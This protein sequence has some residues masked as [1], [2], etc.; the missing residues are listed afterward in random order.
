LKCKKSL[1]S[2][3]L[4]L[5]LPASLN[6]CMGSRTA[7]VSSCTLLTAADAQAALGGPVEAPF[8]GDGGNT[9]PKSAASLCDY[10]LKLKTDKTKV[11]MIRLF[12]RWFDREEDAAQT[13]VGWTSVETQSSSAPVRPVS[14]L[15][16]QAIWVPGTQQLGVLKGRIM[17]Y[18]LVMEIPDSESAAR[19]AAKK[20]LG[21]I[22]ARW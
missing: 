1:L 15:G 16:Q 18:V 7:P 2:T 21:R 14:G 12:V 6:A 4:L 10:K 17:L 22:P 19:A 5:M 3:L 20:V 9:D 11:P 8:E 13:F